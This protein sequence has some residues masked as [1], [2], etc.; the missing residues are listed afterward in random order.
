MEQCVVSEGNYFERVMCQYNDVIY[1][2]LF[3][4]LVLLFNSHSL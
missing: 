1:E 4:T 2:A 3:Q